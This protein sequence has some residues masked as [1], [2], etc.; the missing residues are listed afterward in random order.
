VATR[1]R[2]AQPAPDHDVRVSLVRERIRTGFWFIPLLAVLAAWLVS[3]LMHRLDVAL[4]GDRPGFLA[5][6]GDSTQAALVLSTIAGSTLTFTGIV[7]SITAVALQLG[8]SQF[9]PRALRNFLR[10]RGTQWALGVLV[11][12]FTFSLLTLR[13]IDPTPEEGKVATPGLSVTLGLALV[14]ASLVGF[15]F[16]VNHLAQSIRVVSII[17]RVA[18]ETREAVREMMPLAE[19]VP[20]PD[21]PDR[22]PDQVVTWERGPAAILGYDEDDLVEIA[23]ASGAVL[24]FVRRVGDYV[25]SHA[26]VVEVW[27]TGSDHA[28]VDPVSV[29]RSVGGGIERTMEQDPMFG[30]RQL[31]DIAEKALSPAINDPTTAV[32]SIDRM[33]D[34]LRRIAT[35][36]EP[37]GAYHD[38]DG[39]VRLIV[40]VP[41]WR[42]VVELACNEIRHYGASSMQVVR[43]LRAMF[44]DLLT[45]ATA[46]RAAVLH[47]Q[48]ELLDRAVER[49]YDD[50]HDRAAARRAD[51]QGLGA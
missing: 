9:S 37:T 28:P 27:R 1:R 11:A 46:E 7:F 12:T 19:P 40:P 24:R 20:L 17:E 15:V 23:R 44:D 35:R 48:I 16:F 5:Y 50:P 30:F 51:H 43:R 41:T 33:H 8:S 25:P 21:V 3:I 38:A 18:A 22:P 49:A 32:Q 4:G 14:I 6:D 29:L 31:V 47:E 45:V 10:D 39:T 36:P 42:D 13:Y 2:Q 34:L 26:P